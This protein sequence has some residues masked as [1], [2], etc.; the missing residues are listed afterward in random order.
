MIAM[1]WAMTEDFLIGN[2]MKI[3]WHIK[4]DL[5][6]FKEKTAGKTVL[7][8]ENTYRSLKG[9]Y[10]SRPLPYGKIYVASFTLE[11]LPDA[12]VLRDVISFLKDCKEDLWIV[13]GAT[14]YRLAQAFADRLYIFYILCHYEGDTYLKEIDF[15]RFRLTWQ[16]QTEQVRYTI[17]ERVVE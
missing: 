7:M 9:Y 5:L 6:Y 10:R 3:P 16:K 17:Y 11:S 4:E 2:Q 1:I 12:I 15:S 14:I 13:G 8:G